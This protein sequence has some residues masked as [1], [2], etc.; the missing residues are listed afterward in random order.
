MLVLQIALMC[1]TVTAVPAVIG[2]GLAPVEKNDGTEKLIMGWLVGVHL[3][4][5]VFFSICVPMTLAGKRFGNVLKLYGGI[6]LALFLLAAFLRILGNRYRGKDLPAV[7]HQPKRKPKRCEMAF[8]ILA[9]LLF[10][11]QLTCVFLLA[12]EEGDDA[13]YVAVT[14]MSRD[15]D[16]LYTKIPYTGAFTDLPGRY[17]LAPFP[18]WVA[19]LAK[20]AGLSGATT[21]HLVMP[22]LIL[23]MAYACY[24]L[25][26]KKLLEGKEKEWQLPLYMC[27]I[28]LLVIFGGYSTYTKEN[29]LLVRAGQGKAVLANVVMPFLFY[30]LYLL[31]ER[32]E[33]RKKTDLRIWIQFVLTVMAGCLCSTLGSVLLCML[34]AIGIFLGALCYRKWHLIFLA[35][36]SAIVPGIIILLYLKM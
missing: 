22:V 9:V 8:W 18:V 28:E 34:L 19:V 2:Y 16:R 7:S 21:A 23:C 17:A 4:W 1:L 26:G 33:E 6:C 25:I 30:L 15:T 29:F 20:I 14:T 24:Y 10:I 3:M 11:I 5:A 32:L 13:Y 12:Y 27:L 35:L 36:P 31:M